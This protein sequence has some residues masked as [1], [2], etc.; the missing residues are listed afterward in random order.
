M[1]IAILGWGSLLWDKENSIEFD[2]WHDP[3]VFDGPALKVEFSRISESRLGAL[4]LVI[5]EE[6]GS[7]VRVAWCF[8]KRTRVEDA[9]CDLRCREGTTAAKIGLLDFTLSTDHSNIG[10]AESRNSI[11]EWARAKGMDAVVWTAL[12]SKFTNERHQPFSVDNAVSYLRGLPPEGKSKAAEYVWR[13]PA[14]VETLLRSAL[15][16]EPWFQEQ[17]PSGDP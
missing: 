1:K 5:D 3:W 4:T 16:K 11:L 17:R 13:A 7:S 6:H 14:F 9:V 15:Q 8:S 10:T 12:E 2:K